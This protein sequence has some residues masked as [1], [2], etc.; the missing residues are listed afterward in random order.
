MNYFQSHSL[1]ADAGIVAAWDSEMARA[2]EIP[3]LAR[4]IAERGAEVYP[5]FAKRYAEVRALS[6]GARRALQRRLAASRDLAQIPAEWQ[7]RLA[8]S[9]AGAA[10]LLVLSEAPL[11]AATINVGPGCTLSDAILSANRDTSYGSCT[12]GAS[13]P[14]TIVIPAKSKIVLTSILSIDYG[15]AGLPTV[16]TPITITGNGASISRSKKGQKMRLMTVGATGDLTLNNLTLSG[17]YSYYAGGAI[18]NAGILEVNNCIF[19]GNTAYA[20]AVAN[21]GANPYNLN[22]IG[23]T[24]ITGTTFTKNFGY[25]YGGGVYNVLGTMDIHNSTIT[26]NRAQYGGGITNGDNGILEIENSTV[27]KNTAYIGGGISN[28]NGH[29][30]IDP[31]TITGNKAYL[32]GG[33]ATAYGTVNIDNSTIV[34]NSSRAG[35]GGIANFNS[36]LNVYNS[37]LIT[38]NKG[39]PF[40]GG[41]LNCGYFTLTNSTITTNSAKAAG[42][43]VA[44]ISGT[45]G[46]YSCSYTFINNGT[47]SGNKAKVYAN[48]FYY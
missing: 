23:T 28:Y 43:G 47:V 42:G 31:T 36:A 33:I 16:T 41:V 27:S 24:T 26:G 8:Y 30:T 9:I 1:P 19:S 18:Y 12:A 20:G 21:F 10:L 11:R 34:K 2:K 44:N 7:R 37:S 3:S 48:I 25:K 46:P 32:G 35:G 17:G 38:G 4:L 22:A 14:D 40:G 15:T 29:V 13:G 39:G 5:E 45:Y 6:R